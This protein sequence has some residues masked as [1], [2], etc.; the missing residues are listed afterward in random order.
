MKSRTKSLALPAVLT[1]LLPFYVGCSPKPLPPRTLPSVAPTTQP[2]A[3]LLLTPE[4]E[5]KPMYR[6]VL[7]IDLPTVLRLTA[8][9]S[10]DI[11]QAKERID[12]SRGAYQAS[13]GAVFPVISPG[14]TYQHLEGVNQNANGTLVST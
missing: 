14:V 8:A 3:S 9:N 5:I 6:E 2:T 1:L 7:A 10:I 4:Q 11:Q 12:A 13:V